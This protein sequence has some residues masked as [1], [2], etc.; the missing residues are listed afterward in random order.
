MNSVRKPF[1]SPASEGGAQAAVP[2]ATRSPADAGSATASGA[3]EPSADELKAMAPLI[4]APER[5]STSQRA[6]SR[7]FT[8]LAWAAYMWLIAP[9]LTSLAWLLGIR[10]AWLE[11]SRPLIDGTGAPGLLLPILAGVGAGLLLLWGEFN[12]WRFTG[13][14]RRKHTPPVTDAVV[15]KALGAPPDLADRVRKSF[16]ELPVIVLQMN[17]QAEPEGFVA[18]MEPPKALRRIMK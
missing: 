1:D 5:A 10:S 12:R 13:V 8:T 18:T 6:L 16:K 17:E 4:I 9:L 3:A 11:L 2:D 14:E 7:L 15:A